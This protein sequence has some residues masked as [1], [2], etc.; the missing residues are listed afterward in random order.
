MWFVFFFKKKKK[1]D[2]STRRLK[3][4][5]KSNQKGI[6]IKYA[7]ENKQTQSNPKEEDLAQTNK[8]NS[9]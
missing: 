2:H 9:I 1:T 3:L 5:H 6:K 7:Q 8:K 4:I